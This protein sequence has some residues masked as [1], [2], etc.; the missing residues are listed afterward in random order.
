MPRILEHIDAI[1]RKLQRDVLYLTFHGKDAQPFDQVEVS[2]QRTQIINWLDQEK[3]AWKECGPIA[4]E[5][6]F[7]SYVGQIFID[8]PFDET[9]EE[10]RKLQAFLEHPDGSMR[11]EDVC[12]YIVPLEVAMKNAHHDEPGFWKRWAERF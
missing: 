1:A 9:N 10:Y 8:T 11:Y 6:G 3:I 4:S 12:F 2:P 7:S 5:N